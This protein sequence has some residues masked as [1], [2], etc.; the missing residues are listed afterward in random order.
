MGGSSASPISTRKRPKWDEVFKHAKFSLESIE[1]HTGKLDYYLQRYNGTKFDWF[2]VETEYNRIRE[3][4]YNCKYEEFG[5]ILQNGLMNK[6]NQVLLALK[7]NDKGY[8]LGIW[9]E[10]KTVLKEVRGEYSNLSHIVRHNKFQKRWNTHSSSPIGDK[11]KTLTHLQRI[12]QIVLDEIPKEKEAVRS[13]VLVEVAK[14][15]GYK[16]EMMRSCDNLWGYAQIED[17]FPFGDPLPYKFPLRPYDDWRYR[18]YNSNWKADIDLVWEK[19]KH[20]PQ[21]GGKDE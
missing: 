13:I 11:I 10:Y 4:C 14:R 9:G 5:R 8:A 2:M 15:L 12:T 17:T 20:M 6:L 18:L 7:R 19:V 1:Y 21:K 3:H 16:A